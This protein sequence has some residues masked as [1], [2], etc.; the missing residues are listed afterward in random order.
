MIRSWDPEIKGPR[1]RGL[2][3]TK[4]EKRAVQLND[5]VKAKVVRIGAGKRRNAIPVVLFLFLECDGELCV[6]M[7][8]KPWP[9][10]LL[11][12]AICAVVAGCA[13]PLWAKHMRRE[14]Q[15]RAGR[16]G[17]AD[18]QIVAVDRDEG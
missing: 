18:H 17:C 11:V 10:L 2:P 4:D 15:K 3:T 5:A 16:A 14:A 7:H 9:K 8:T 6:D 13:M 1:G 12:E